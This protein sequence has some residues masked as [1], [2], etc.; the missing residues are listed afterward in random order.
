MTMDIYSSVDD[1][2]SSIEEDNHVHDDQPKYTNTL[3]K[4]WFRSKT[5]S[6]FLSIRPWF[7]AMKFSIDIGKTNPDGKLVSSTNCFVDAIDFAAYLKA[8][9]NGNAIANFPANERMNL[10]YAESFVSYGGSSANGEPISRIFKVHYWQAGETVDT[11][12][13]VWKTGHFKARKSE[14]GAFIPD[15][16]SPLSIDSIKV[17]RQD[18]VSISYLLDLSLISHTVNTT[19]WY[20]A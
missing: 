11:N 14:S 5:Q 19:D 4:K 18:M 10:P 13:F 1:I 20:D 2:I 7:Q 8:V 12:A 17:T 16:K 15:M 6:G 9:V 3:Y